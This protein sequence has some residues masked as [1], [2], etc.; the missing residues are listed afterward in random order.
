VWPQL[1]LLLVNVYINVANG[2]VIK[3]GWGRSF[4]AET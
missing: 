2:V 3:A 4:K 1:I